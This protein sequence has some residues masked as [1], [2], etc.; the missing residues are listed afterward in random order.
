MHTEVAFVFIGQAA[1]QPPQFFASLVVSTQ[2]FEQRMYDP[3]QAIEHWLSEQIGLA[4]AG[5]GQTL[6]HMPQF[7][8]LVARSTHEPLQLV[9]PPVHV[10]L[11]VPSVHTCEAVQAVGQVPQCALSDL[12]STQDPLQLV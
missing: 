12:R 6:P 3:V 1:P 4:L 10:S 9:V 11:H 7:E 2:L 5:A 8:V